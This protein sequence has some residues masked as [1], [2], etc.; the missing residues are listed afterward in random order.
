MCAQSPQTAIAI[1]TSS[2]FVLPIGTQCIFPRP[3]CCHYFDHSTF[4]LYLHLNRYFLSPRCVVVC[5]CLVSL[6]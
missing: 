1:F 6:R 4:N 2:I 5:L 3:C